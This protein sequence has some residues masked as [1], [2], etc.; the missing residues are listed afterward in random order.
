MK[1][2]PSRLDHLRSVAEGFRSRGRAHY[3]KM[4]EANEKIR[5][6][7]DSIGRKGLATELNPMG[8]PQFEKERREAETRIAELKI[9]SNQEAAL[10]EAEREK[11][12][13]ASVLAQ[14][15]EEYLE[16]AR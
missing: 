15:C 6:I 12:T 3:D 9:V 5:S 4:I 13:Q 2:D 10:T 11:A 14:R 8:R 1:L 16:D 7:R